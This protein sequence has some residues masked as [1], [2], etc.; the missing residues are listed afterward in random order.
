MTE[1][2]WRELVEQCKQGEKKAFEAL[3][4]ETKRSVYFTALKMLANEEKAKDVMQDT[5]ITA[6]EKLDTLED[7][8]IFPKWVNSIAVNKCRRY[9]RKPAEDSLDEQLEQGFEIKDDE[10][11]IPDEYAASEEKRKVIM[12]I[13]THSVSDIQRQTII[14]YS[15]SQ[16]SD[17]HMIS[18]CWDDLVTKDADQTDIVL[19]VKL[20]VYGADPGTYS[21]TLDLTN[22]LANSDYNVNRFDV[23]LLEISVTVKPEATDPTEPPEETAP[24]FPYG[25]AV[26]VSKYV[27][28]GDEVDLR[29]VIQNYNGEPL[30]EFISEYF[31]DMGL[32]PQNVTVTNTPETGEYCRR[33]AELRGYSFYCQ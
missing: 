33:E 9:F 32:R 24:A 23:E 12:D 20:E 22:C 8:A 25:I 17:N 3:Y 27:Y 16:Y 26:P 19:P 7:G 28:P 10:S 18:V 29:F 14:I 31:C 30:A 13:I 21:C 2:K 5:F 6:I 4:N 15:G 1:L 11:F